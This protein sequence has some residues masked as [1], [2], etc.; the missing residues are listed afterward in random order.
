MYSRC[1]LTE[2]NEEDSWSEN[3]CSDLLL[4]RAIQGT[5]NASCRPAAAT[6]AHLRGRRQGL[7]V[8][9]GTLPRLKP[10]QEIEIPMFYNYL[11]CLAETVSQPRLLPPLVA[12]LDARHAGVGAPAAHS[13]E[14][15][16]QL[17]LASDGAICR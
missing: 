10:K 3:M 8:I 14:L 15:L 11:S 1:K 6:P 2:R 9:R 16:V 12:Q 5:S 4:P 13:A 17:R 7:G